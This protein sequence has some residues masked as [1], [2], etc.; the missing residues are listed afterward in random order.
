LHQSFFNLV[1][2]RGHRAMLYALPGVRLGPRSTAE[3]LHAGEFGQHDE[4]RI[5]NALRERVA[6]LSN[7]T[8]ASRGE[9][10]IRKLS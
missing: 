8:R 2:Q 6:A 7:S 4:E 3:A 1:W 5:A 10:A 9:K